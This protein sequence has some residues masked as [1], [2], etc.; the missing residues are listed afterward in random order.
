MDAGQ[1]LAEWR[2]ARGADPA[3]ATPW[4]Y[5][6]VGALHLT[7][8]WWLHSGECTSSE[9]A[10]Q[11]TGFDGTVTTRQQSLQDRLKRNQTEQDRL[12]DRIAQRQERLLQQYQALDAK[13]GQ[14]SSLSAYVSQQMSLLNKQSSSRD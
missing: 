1:T 9:L 3:A 5:A 12:E 14:L 2:V 6:I 13:I 7:V 11:L 8:L 4:A 10:D